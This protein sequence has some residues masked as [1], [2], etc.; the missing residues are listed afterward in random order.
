MNLRRAYMQLI[1]LFDSLGHWLQTVPAKAN[2][3][4]M[5]LQAKKVSVMQ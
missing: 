2:T 1:L 3:L 5:R 4:Q